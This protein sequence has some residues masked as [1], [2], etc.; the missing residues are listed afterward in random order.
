LKITTNDSLEEEMNTTPRPARVV[1]PGLILNNELEARGWTQRDLAIIVGRPY[2]AINEIINGGKQI[3]PDTARELAR[4]FDTSIDFWINLEANYR[5]HLAEQ[6]EKEKEIIQRSR[7]YNFAPIREMIKRSW[8]KG[9]DNINELE[10]QVCSFFEISSLDDPLVINASLRHSENRDVETASL[11]A[12]AQQVKN[13]AK[14]QSVGKFSISKLNDAIPLLFNSS[15]SLEFISKVPDFLHDLG[16]CFVL[17]PH[18]PHTYIDGA[19]I[20]TNTNPIIALTLRYDRLD[21]FW[22]TLAHELAHVVSGHKGIILDDT[23]QRTGSANKNEENEA[24]QLASEWLVNQKLLSKYISDVKPY[25]SKD[26]IENF[27]LNINR[28]PA[29][30]LGQ[31]HNKKE[32]EYKNLRRML[33]KV[34]PYL[35]NWIYN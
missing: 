11:S 25:F 32:V 19:A 26:S 18:L 15:S 35:G 34:K 4:A 20:I 7:L 22:F 12:W 29:I 5:L 8:I 23:E 31:L 24:N 33:V 13:L 9:T 3:T 6:D 1:S 27:A 14:E 17:L 2:Q 28:H 21:S 16:L 10:Q 30:V